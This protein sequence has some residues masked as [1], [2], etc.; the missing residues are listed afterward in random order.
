MDASQLGRFIQ[1]I[2]MQT[3]LSRADIQSSENAIYIS[4]TSASP[5]TSTPLRLQISC[6]QLD[7]QLSSM[8]QV[9]DQF[10]PFLF[11]V[12][13]LGINST[14]SPSGQDDVD[15]EQW[16]ELVHTFVGAEDFRVAGVH[17]KDILRALHPASREHTAGTTTSMLPALRNL[18]V[19]EPIAM[20]GP[21]WD[22]VQSF[23]TSRSL[24]GRPV[25]VNA[26]S[27]QCHICRASFGQEQIIKVHLREV[28]RY[29]MMCSYCGDFEFAPKNNH[30][31]QEHLKN[32]HPEVVRNSFNCFKSVPTKPNSTVSLTIT[33]LRARQ[34]SLH[35]YPSWRGQG[36]KT[37]GGE[38]RRYIQAPTGN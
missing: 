26:P 30:L 28:H 22:A 14:Q 19:E 27:Y 32:K 17:V 1:R 10:S 33:V 16:P 7:W 6:E 4:F 8:A 24:S 3:L 12:S 38:R 15:G 5:R 20:D 31:F 25:Q 11:R 35:P 29:K 37:S 9:C 2:E 18:R 21:S 13:D 36:R 23:I 34:T